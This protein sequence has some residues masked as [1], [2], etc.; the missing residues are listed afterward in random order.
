VATVAPGAT[1]AAATAAGE[2]RSPLV[3]V[4]Q[5]PAALQTQP[6]IIVDCEVQL[7]ARSSA[8]AARACA[9]VSASPSR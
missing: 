2:A 6:A 4:A 8:W 9:P 5:V 1:V 3:A 7:R